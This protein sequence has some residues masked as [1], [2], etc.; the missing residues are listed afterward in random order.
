MA[1]AIYIPTHLHTLRFCL[2]LSLFLGS[3]FGF[4]ELFFFFFFFFLQFK[5]V[6]VNNSF[7]Y[8]SSKGTKGRL[9]ISLI[10]S[11]A[12]YFEAT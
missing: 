4:I 6:W 11:C 10:H 3:V 2:V 5:Y 12:H 7:R 1:V 9:V 8:E